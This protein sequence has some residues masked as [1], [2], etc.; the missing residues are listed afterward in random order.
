[1]SNRENHL[2]KPSWR[3]AGLSAPKL[4]VLAWIVGIL[5][6]VVGCSQKET[7][8]ST[9]LFLDYSFTAE[10]VYQKIRIEHS[11][12]IYTYFDDVEGECSQ[13]LEQTPCWIGKDLTTREI[14]LSPNEM[15]DLIDLIEQTGFLELEDVYGGAEP[16]QRHYSHRL[17]VRLGQREKEVVY[18]DFP[19]ASPMP[20]AFSQVMDG[21]FGFLE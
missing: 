19:D 12:L 5:L 17:Y 1:M 13:W 6:V 2:N 20:E 7:T 3:C 16:G 9:E 15:D 14:S 8:P 11:N 21:L 4:I 18:Q 10:T